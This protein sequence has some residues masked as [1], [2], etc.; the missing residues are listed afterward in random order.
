MRAAA[1]VCV[2]ARSGRGRPLSLLPQLGDVLKTRRE[3]PCI[4]DNGA[5]EGERQI[6]RELIP[7]RACVAF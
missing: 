1:V 3:L 5:V 4:R 6:A 7:G 2:C